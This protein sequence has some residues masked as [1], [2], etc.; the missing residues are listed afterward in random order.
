VPTAARIQAS[1]SGI[2]IADG[3]SIGSLVFELAPTKTGEQPK[4]EIIG[5]GAVL[6]ATNDFL[7]IARVL[8]GGGAAAVGLRAG[9]AILRVDGIPVAELGMSAAIER[10]RGPEGSVVALTVR[11]VLD[12]SVGEVAVP[13]VPFSY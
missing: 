10:I 13:R 1:R 4:T 3:A 2:A 6:Q 7:T 8:P 11:R 12:G 9:D 5:I